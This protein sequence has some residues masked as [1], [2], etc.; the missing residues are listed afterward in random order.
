MGATK[1]RALVGQQITSVQGSTVADQPVPDKTLINYLGTIA[2]E[3]VNELKPILT[4][5]EVTT[6]PDL[7]GKYTEAAVRQLVKRIVYPM[8]VCTGAVIDHPMPSSLMQ[9]DLIIWSPHPAP[10]IF[11]VE[12]FG[13][14]PL[15]SAFGVVEIKRSNYKSAIG[16]IDKFHEAAHARRIVSSPKRPLNDFTFVPALTVICWLDKNISKPLSR[17]IDEGKVVAIF[18]RDPKNPASKPSR[19]LSVQSDMAASCARRCRGD[20]SD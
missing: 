15:S 1:T 17:L 4:I 19:E 13:L 3:L 20:H 8:R 10:A 6:N 16:S 14:V 11:E 7:L 5:K 2:E 9:I 18:D 12:G